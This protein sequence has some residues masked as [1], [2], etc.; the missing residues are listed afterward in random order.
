MSG[1][2]PHVVILGAGFGGMGVVKELARAGVRVTLIDRNNYH[3][4]QPLLYQVATDVLASSEVGFPVRQLLHGHPD[5]AFH[6][7]MV[8]GVDL[9]R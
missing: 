8:T 7:V 1:P 9:A 2:S 6:K 5:W 4:F 3:T